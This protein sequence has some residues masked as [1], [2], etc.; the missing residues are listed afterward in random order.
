MSC[1]PKSFLQKAPSSPTA[2]RQLGMA[3][4]AIR[5]Q[6]LSPAERARAIAHLGHILILASGVAIAERD[7]DGA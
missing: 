3:F 4:D 1:R 7:D 6:G 2:S 5:L